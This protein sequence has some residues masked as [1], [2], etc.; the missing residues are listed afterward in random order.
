MA[1]LDCGDPAPKLVRGL[2]PRDYHRHRKAGDLD[3]I[4]LP[5]KP[6]TSRAVGSRERMSD[7]TISV[8]L[9]DG[10]FA[11]EHRLVM[12]QQLGRELLATEGVYHRNGIK[13][14]N[15]PENLTLRLTTDAPSGQ[16]VD[17]LVAYVGSYHPDAVLAQI[18]TTADPLHG[19]LLACAEHAYTATQQTTLAGARTHVARA[20]RDLMDASFWLQQL[21]KKG[22]A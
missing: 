7:G 4:A 9:P 1:C 6:A 18:F 10:T 20:M 17:D 15:R 22:A 14:D 12:A 13:D 3:D 21:E 19:Y 8:K 16:T 5:P 11:L 2:C